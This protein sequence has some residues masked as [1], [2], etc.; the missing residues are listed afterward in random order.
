MPYNPELLDLMRELGIDP[1]F[2]DMFEQLLFTRLDTLIMMTS[3]NNANL[4]TVVNAIESNSDILEQLVYYY[5]N[6]PVNSFYQ[7]LSL[8]RG[9]MTAI[10]LFILIASSFKK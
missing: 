3:I 9:F 8:I 1:A 10:L 5:Q 4:N 6:Q 2:S 7:F